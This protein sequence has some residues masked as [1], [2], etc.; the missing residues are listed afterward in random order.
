M[1]VIRLPYVNVIVNRREWLDYQRRLY[2]WHNQTFFDFDAVL[3]PLERR[4]ID[5]CI[6][7][8]ADSRWLT[9]YFSLFSYS[10]RVDPANR[11]IN[12]TR[13]AY[14]TLRGSPA[15]TELGKEIARAKGWPLN[16][17]W[18]CDPNL[19]FYGLGWDFV[20]QLDKV[21]FFVE[22]VAALPDQ[23]KSMAKEDPMRLLKRGIV[24]Q[25]FREGAIA[26]E[27]LYVFPRGNGGYGTALLYSGARSLL[28][29]NN[30]AHFGRRDLSRFSPLSRQIAEAYLE[31]M[32]TLLDTYSID[33]HTGIETLYFDYHT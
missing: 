9:P 18:F 4:F 19:R 2:A 3:T 17:N 11:D 31:Q 24:S 25:S 26:E 16:M 20:D 7:R 13:L 14:G 5:L 30:H 22:D 1:K 8:S 28:Q 10:H 21:Y 12:S 33:E 15:I 27:K 6:E 29:Q 23:L 32:G